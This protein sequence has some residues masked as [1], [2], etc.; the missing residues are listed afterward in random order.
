MKAYMHKERGEWQVGVSIQE[1]GEDRNAVFH[2]QWD[3]TVPGS[4]NIENMV[5]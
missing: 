1:Q 3:Y 4:T 5:P 2:G